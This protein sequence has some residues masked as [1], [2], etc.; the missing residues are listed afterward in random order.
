MRRLLLAAALLSAACGGS[1][2]TQPN[3]TPKPNPQAQTWTISGTVTTTLT[4]EPVGGASV[5]F[6]SQTLT[7]NSAGRWTLTG[8]GT[9]SGSYGVEVSAAGHLTRKTS[10]RA[11]NGRDVTIDLI[12]DTAPF[13]LPLYR[14]LVR[15]DFDQPGQ[16]QWT[17]RWTVTPKFYI[18]TR[19]PRTGSH[20]S[21]IEIEAFSGAIHRV[22]SQVIGVAPAIETGDGPRESDGYIQVSIV[23]EPGANYC[24]TASVGSNPGV[25]YINYADICNYGFYGCSAI[26]AVSGVMAHEVGHALGLWHGTS[27]GSMDIRPHVSRCNDLQL[28][29]VEQHHARVLYS[30]PVGNADVDWDQSS[31]PLLRASLNQRHVVSCFRPR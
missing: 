5:A 24:G 12:R 26:G 6:S 19:N 13:S 15:N 11:E 7:T 21:A 4:G 20:I 3:P 30:R 28:S 9:P 17:R 1:T 8:T 29:P 2:P 10:I 23:N 25:I 31:T 27:G 16:L 22:V 14:Q 18:N